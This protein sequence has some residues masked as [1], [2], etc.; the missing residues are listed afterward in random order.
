MSYF[1]RIRNF[2][3]KQT[4]NFRVL[5]VTSVSISSISGL[6]T[7]GGGVGGGGGGAS[8][9]TLYIR[10]LG[11]DAQQIGVINSSGRIARA[12][13]GLPLGWISDRFSLKKVI[14][15]GLI[16]SVIVPLAYVLSTTWDQAVP[17]MMISAI[18]QTLT[19]MFINIFFVT[20]MR[21]ASDRATAMSLKSILTSL[22]GLAIPTIS[23]IIVLQSGGIGVEGIR[24]L[25]IIQIFCSIVVLIYTALTLKEVGFLQQK[26]KTV[27]KKKSIFQD[28]KEIAKIP[29]VQKWT[30]TKGLRTFFGQSLLPFYS[31]YY[32]EI[33]GADPLIIGAM[34]TIGTVGALLF[35]APFGRLADKHGRKKIIYLTRPFN[36]LAL[37]IIVVAPAPEWLILAAFLRAFNIV[38]SLM[39]ITMEHELVS[40]EQRGRWGGFLLFFMGFVGIP[41]PI[42]AGY[43][44]NII[45]PSLLLLTPIIA[46]LPFLA[47]LPTIPDTLHMVYEQNDTSNART[48]R[49]GSGTR[50]Q[51]E[52]VDVAR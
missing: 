46:D 18:A 27:Q 43:L 2:I 22:V 49:T 20:S 16:L 32:V 3:G 7:G 25:F 30:I 24:P 52:N 14:L 31:L 33:K 21:E 4:E 29:A 50:G 48:S 11:A 36:C 26:E 37:F 45:D 51:D 5:L 42:L 47:I 44:W 13:F 10:A 12:L 38:S 34:D 40:E 6:V 28:Y 23:A 15:A 19:G 17:A 39:E 8:Y 41:G 1:W 9:I 35:L